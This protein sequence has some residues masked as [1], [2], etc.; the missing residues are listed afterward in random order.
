MISVFSDDEL[1]VSVISI[2]EI[3]KGITLLDF[4]KRKQALLTWVHSLERSYADRLL[5]VDL[6]IVRL[7]GE[8]TAAARK[9][10]FTVP[11]C[12]GL[13]ASTAKHH[14]LHLMTRNVKDFRHI[15]VMMINPWDEV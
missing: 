4:S 6:E 12:D 9:K 3:V 1:F 14:G 7:W 2:G 11:V 15:G 8:T 13:I 10:G 5:P